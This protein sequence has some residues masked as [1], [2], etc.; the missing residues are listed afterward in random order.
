MKEGLILAAK[1][2]WGC[3][4][5]NDLGI[6]NTLKEYTSDGKYHSEEKI[7]EDLKKLYSYLYYRI[8]A[9]SNNIKDPFGLK[10]VKAHWIGN[11]LLKNVKDSV[12]RKV[13]KEMEANHDKVT[14]GYVLMPLIKKTGLAHHNFYARHNPECSVTTDGEHFFHLGERRIGTNPEDIKNLKKYGGKI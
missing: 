14:L 1:F 3:K 11:E 4:R 12:V 2:S 8:I 9:E 13:F 7:S 5:A 10:V 6:T